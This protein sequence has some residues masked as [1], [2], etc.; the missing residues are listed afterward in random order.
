MANKSIKVTCQK[1]SVMAT[2]MGWRVGSVKVASCLSVCAFPFLLMGC[3]ETMPLQL[4]TAI[5]SALAS[6]A[7]PPLQTQGGSPAKNDGSRSSNVGQSVNEGALR[8]SAADSK[9]L[10]TSARP[11]QNGATPLK[12]QDIKKL[13]GKIQVRN[14]NVAKTSAALLGQPVELVL[15]H[16]F[17]KYQSESLSVPG[18][19]AIEFT[20]KDHPGAFPPGKSSYRV[21]TKITKVGTSDGPEGDPYVDIQLEKCTD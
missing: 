9:N 15:K 5:S 2:G 16:P 21:S 14:Y 10:T 1:N 12:A 18:L 3:V 19:P 17:P 20:C 8:V 4:Q 6:S 7:T 11:T 13:V